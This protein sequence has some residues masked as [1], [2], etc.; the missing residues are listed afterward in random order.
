MSHSHN[1]EYESDCKGCCKDVGARQSQSGSIIGPCSSVNVIGDWHC[2]CKTCI[3]KVT[4]NE[5]CDE[6]IEFY[7]YRYNHLQQ[8]SKL[9]QRTYR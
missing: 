1:I 3:V 4:C 5:Y 8:K 6:C 2:P 7:T 9:R